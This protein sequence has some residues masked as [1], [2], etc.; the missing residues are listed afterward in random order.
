MR[1]SL[2]TFTDRH[3]RTLLRSS[4]VKEPDERLGKLTEVCHDQGS[5]SWCILTEKRHVYR[6]AGHRWEYCFCVGDTHDL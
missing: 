3:I 1:Q 6:Y 5:G 2:R 4:G